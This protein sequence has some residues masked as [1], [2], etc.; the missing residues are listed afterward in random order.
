MRS[1]ATW[2]SLTSTSSPPAPGSPVIGSGALT[3]G[4][5][6]GLTAPAGSSVDA[7]GAALDMDPMTA[8]MN[9]TANGTV[10]S[11]TD[12]SGAVNIT[13]GTLIGGSTPTVE[14]SG[15]AGDIDIGASV[16]AGSA[17]AVSI[18]SL[19]TTA[20]IDF[21][22]TVTSNSATGGGGISVTNGAGTNS[23]T[24]NGNVDLGQTT[25]L[26]STGL[27]MTGNSGGTTVAFGDLDITTS[28]ADGIFGSTDGKLTT[29]AGSTVDTTNSTAIN[30]TGL[31]FGGASL[32]FSNVDQTGTG[33]G[34]NLAS[35]TGT[36]N[37]GAV[38]INATG[39][40]LFAGTAG[41][42]TVNSTSGHDRGGRRRH[43]RHGPHH[44]PGPDL[45]LNGRHRRHPRHLPRRHRRLARRWRRRHHHRHQRGRRGNRWAARAPS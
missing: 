45:D 12:V 24:F 1:A 43:L 31:D 19:L 44:D 34:I 21:N 32:N 36:V 18:S 10:V 27:T 39:T 41:T 8:A 37:L 15:G 4:T 2:S 30:I 20:D 13:G 35:I 23:V 25:A 11:L 16:T 22:S 42:A 38:S 17:L 33:N 6:F 7:S 3:A 28:N 5:G 14:I 9:L 26:T 40:G 29:A